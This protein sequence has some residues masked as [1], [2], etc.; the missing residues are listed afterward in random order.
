MAIK[1][2]EGWTED[3]F[4]IAALR[5]HNIPLL[6]SDEEARLN[7][8]NDHAGTQ[9]KAERASKIAAAASGGRMETLA[10]ALKS[11]ELSFSEIFRETRKI[12]FAYKDVSERQK[13]LVKLKEWLDE[14]KA[15]S[16]AYEM[17]ERDVVSLL[18]SAFTSIPGSKY[19][20]VLRLT[21]EARR[22]HITERTRKIDVDAIIA[23]EQSKKIGTLPNIGDDTH[24]HKEADEPKSI[25]LDEITPEEEVARGR[26]LPKRFNENATAF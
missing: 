6:G 25:D 23:D 20:E 7:M 8:S 14:A 13:A 19:V 24:D 22:K 4:N 18:V 12:A 3:G 15:Q 16:E 21:H 1:L 5:E 9:S 10:Q 11:G 2:S 17:A 26:R